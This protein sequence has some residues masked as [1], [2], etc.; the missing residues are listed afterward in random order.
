M[1]E[2]IEVRANTIYT[3]DVGK[4]KPKLEVIIIHTDGMQ[5]IAKSEKIVTIPILKESR[6]MVTERGLDELIAD[7]QK[8]KTSMVTLHQN[9]KVMNDIVTAI[10]EGPSEKDTTAQQSTLNL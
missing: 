9:C 6:F 8:W 2:V 1:K 4:L 5:Y 10:N 3:T 7:L